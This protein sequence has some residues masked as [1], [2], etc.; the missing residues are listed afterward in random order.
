MLYVADRG[1]L[2]VV[3]TDNWT[4][5]GATPVDATTYNSGLAVDPM[6]GFVFLLDSVGG[7]LTVLAE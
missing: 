2:L 5:L 4:L 6:G 7:Q 1:E 3:D